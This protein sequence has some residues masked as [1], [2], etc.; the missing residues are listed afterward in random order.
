SLRTVLL[1]LTILPAA[2][3]YFIHNTAASFLFD[4]PWIYSIFYITLATSI[5]VYRLSPF[6][7]LASY[8]GPLILRVTKLW[9]AWVAYKGKTH[10]YFKELHEKY[11]PTIRIGPNELSTVEKGFISQILGNQ[12]MPKGPLWDGRR[13]L[14]EADTRGYDNIVDLRDSV[15][16]AQLRKPWN[17]AFTAEPLKDYEQLV[18]RRVVELNALL[19]DV[20][21]LNKGGIGRVDIAKWVNSF[22]YDLMGDMAFSADYHLMKDGDKDNRFETMVN[23]VFNV[24]ITQHIPWIA[25]TVRAFPGLNK[26]MREFTDY[27]IQQAIKR[28]NTQVKRKDLFYYMGEATGSSDADLP[29]IIT[30]VLLAIFAGSDTTATV[31]SAAFYL[32]LTN[33]DKYKALQSEID[34]AFVEHGIDFGASNTVEVDAD[35][36]PYGEVLAGL[37]YLNGVINETLRL[38][39]IVPTAFQRAP[40]K[41]SKLKVLQSGDSAI[42]LPEGNAIWVPAY[43]L[44]RD[45]RYFSPRPDDFIPERWHSSPSSKEYITSRDAFIPFSVGPQ[46][47]A[48][49]SMA[50]LELRYVLATLVR[51]FE[52]EFDTPAYDPSWWERDLEDRYTFSKGHLGVR[53]RLR[54]KDSN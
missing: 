32:L 17:R 28:A 36:K 26:W 40:A 14:K 35:I 6:H 54:G 7:P 53:L 1:A 22:A 18:I 33:P 34:N 39:P 49:R 3:T 2:S 37:E 46:N 50:L 41:G 52:M 23:A 48:G 51:N 11:G 42:Y 19:E 47:C 15:L 30:N 4:L 25:R 9:L 5:C 31:I 8:P 16:H 10:L 24:S 44:H 43:V 38:Y 20:C 45:P 21:N 29:L 13:F 12:G 27:G